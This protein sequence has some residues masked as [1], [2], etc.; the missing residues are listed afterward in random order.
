MQAASK[1]MR[2]ATRA[3]LMLAILGVSHSAAAQTMGRLID[4]V[5]VNQTDGHIDLVVQFTCGMRYLGHTPASHGTTLRVRLVPAPGCG[6]GPQARITPERA[7]AAD[8][9]VQSIE[10][11][12]L[13]AQELALTVQWNKEEDF[14]L[15]P[16]TDLNGIRI[17]LPRSGAQDKGRVYINESSGTAEAY[18]INLQS[19]LE[20]FDPQALAEVRE[21]FGI[22]PYVSRLA[23]DGTT[24]YRLR[25][26]PF[27]TKAEAERLLATARTTYPR[28]WLAIDDETHDEQDTVTAPLTPTRTN[29]SAVRLSADQLAELLA[30]A[31]RAL[32]G[33]DFANAIGALTRLVEQPEYAGRADALELLGLARERNRQLAHAKAEYEEYLRLYP[34]SQNAARVRQRLRALVFSTRRDADNRV[35]LDEAARSPWR[36]YGGA[37][38]RYQRDTN[39]VQATGQSLNFTAQNSIITDID[40]VVRRKGSRFDLLGRTS[41]GYQKDLLDDGPGDR[42]RVSSAYAE[43]ADRDWGLSAR[44]GRQSRGAAGLLGSFDGIQL[45]YQMLAQLRINAVFGYPAESSYDSPQTDRSL[46]GLSVDFG[47]WLEAW[48]FSLFAV[49]QRAS[50]LKERQALGTQVQ[51]F[52]PGRSM[53]GLVDYD[54]YYNELNSAV[55]LGVFELPARWTVNFNLDHRASPLIS[56]RNALIGQPVATLDEL[57]TLFSEDQL[58]QL[59]LDRTA[60]SA[61][62][63]VA[64]SRPIT[65]RLQVSADLTTSSIS[66]TPASGGVAAI[67]ASGTLNAYSLQLIGGDW[68]AG[69]D[70]HLVGARYQSGGTSR[71]A[72]LAWYTRFPLGQLWR[73]GPRL[74]V[75]QQRTDAVSQLRYVPSLRVDFI[76]QRNFAILEVGAEIASRKA[77]STNATQQDTTRYYLGAEYRWSF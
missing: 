21:R 53:V 33:K 15:A 38:V 72:S 4:A 75:D 7:D 31:R 32:Q 74:R 54:I 41:L 67:D 50:G 51:Y 22:T 12:Q 40:S 23:V 63:S 28:A 19:G 16:G 20:P 10:L 37:G 1:A 44:L 65:E 52:R 24:W 27:A 9:V 30:Q 48:D 55:L 42:T 17:R 69:N 71:L 36:A 35:V 11:E 39:R 62:Y 25:L 3:V 56:T 49:E 6:I 14:I 13:F 8:P 66:A 57:S 73:I 45:G 2:T 77:N 60:E 61:T 58:R 70:F 59:A 68:L 43:L 64:L 46:S 47:T 29:V 18:A 26:G 76:G 34:R 5:D